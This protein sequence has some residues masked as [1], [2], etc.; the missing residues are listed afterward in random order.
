MIVFFSASVMG[1]SSFVM[2]APLFA[3]LSAISLPLIPQ[4]AGI[5]CSTTLLFPMMLCSVAHFG[6]EGNPVQIGNH[7]YINIDQ[8]MGKVRKKMSILYPKP[9][10]CSVLK[11]LCAIRDNIATCDIASITDIIAMIEDIFIN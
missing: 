1:L 9:I 6:Y 8:L 7:W 3:S 10:L 4:W 2:A 11:E 5:H